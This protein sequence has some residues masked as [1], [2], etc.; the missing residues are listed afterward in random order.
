MKLIGIDIGKNKHFFSIMDKDTG[1]VIEA[2]SSFLNNKEGFDSL[3][4]KLKPYSKDTVLIG[5]EDTGHYHFALLKYLLNRHFTVA[6][7]NPKTTDFTR[8]IQGGITKNDKL[9]TLTICDV[10]ILTNVKNSIVSPKLITLIFMN[11]NN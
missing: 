10:L 5:M 7:I 6:L 11:K 1:E 2:P 4:Q 9:D 3:I 8:K